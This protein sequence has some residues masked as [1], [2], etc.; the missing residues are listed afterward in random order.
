MT[1]EKRTLPLDLIGLK[2]KYIKR[3]GSSGSYQYYYGDDKKK[4]SR[5]TKFKVGDKVK[6]NRDN[7][8]QKGVITNKD[9][10]KKIWVINTG[11]HIYRV[12]ER[13]LQQKKGSSDKKKRLEERKEDLLS[14]HDKAI[15]QG[16]Q[17]RAEKLLQSYNK[18]GR[19]KL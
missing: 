15:E 4:G 19:I 2:H 17:K 16:H 13:D 6:F 8:N 14:K 3:T 12:H 9:P 18:L 5:H 11:T 7:K 10:V 1:I